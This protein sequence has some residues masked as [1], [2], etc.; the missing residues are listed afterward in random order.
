M[1]NWIEELKEEMLYELKKREY[2][3]LS[4]IIEVIQ[5][6]FDEIKNQFKEVKFEENSIVSTKYDDTSRI[7][8]LRF[9]DISYQK[10]EKFII[11]SVKKE[12][13]EELIVVEIIVPQLKSEIIEIATIQLDDYKPSIV[14]NEDIEESNIEFSKEIEDFSYMNFES[15]V[16][17]ILEY[18][19]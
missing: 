9:N 14:Y 17:E 15:L 18:R 11:C 2:N 6:L 4:T 5:S 10:N 8:Q 3:E 7:Y 13:G 1:T 16:R 12:H 19:F